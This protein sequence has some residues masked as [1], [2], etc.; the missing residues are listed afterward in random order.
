ML[1]NFFSF[2]TLSSTQHCSETWL[3]DH[4]T[5]G[6]FCSF[7]LCAS[8]LRLN[9]FGLYIFF[10]CSASYHN[11]NFF[12]SFNYNLWH[13]ISHLFLISLEKSQR[14]PSRHFCAGCFRDSLWLSVLIERRLEFVHFG[15]CARRSIKNYLTSNHFDGV[16]INLHVLQ[17]FRADFWRDFSSAFQSDSQTS[18]IEIDF[19]G[20]MDWFVVKLVKTAVSRKLFW[21]FINDFWSRKWGEKSVGSV[22]CSGLVTNDL[23]IAVGFWSARWAFIMV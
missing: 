2:S 4:R 23:L 14:L 20:N 19:T 1:C 17:R 9:S 6:N 18:G 21:C 8:P 15:C 3:R 16:F 11:L 13:F 10:H 5:C 7:F 22:L 12:L